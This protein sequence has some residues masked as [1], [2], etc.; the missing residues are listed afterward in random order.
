MSTEFDQQS[1]WHER[2]QTEKAFEWLQSSADFV[3]LIREPVL[4]VLPPP[5]SARILQL[6]AGT[7]DLAVQLRAAGF[8]DAVT[9]TDFEPLAISRGRELEREAFGDVRMRYA[10]ADAT[11]LESFAGGQK[12]HLV[13]DKST[14]DAVAC[15]G[16]E[17]LLRM[18]RS[19]KECLVQGGAWV[20]LS[21]SNWRFDSEDLPFDVEVLAKIL[22]PKARPSDPD[23]YHWCYLLTPI[24]EPKKGGAI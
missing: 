9:N 2:F 24:E 17:Q 5:D 22:T 4:D 13:I 6:G 15:G 10:V 18:A 23:Y 7:S 20:S 8:G 16:E 19:V 21:F 3:S 1:Y 14:C 12:Y 11:K